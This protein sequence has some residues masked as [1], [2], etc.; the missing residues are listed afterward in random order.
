MSELKQVFETQA[1]DGIMFAK[2]I[3]WL[4]WSFVVIGVILCLTVI[5]IIPGILFII[6]GL[7]LALF[8]S[9]MLAKRMAQ[10]GRATSEVAEILEN[11]LEKARSEK[12]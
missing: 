10:M 6:M 8:I 11:Q 12:K 9:K 4:G 3:K 2:I 1:K 7:F 5:G